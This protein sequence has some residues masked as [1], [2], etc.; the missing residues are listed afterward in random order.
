MGKRLEAGEKGFDKN[1][2]YSVTEAVTLVKKCA[3]AKF[4]ESIELHAA[5]GI[6]V[7]QADQQVRGTLN[8]PHGTGKSKR[9]AVIAK[10][11]KIKEAQAAGA[12]LTGAEDLIDAIS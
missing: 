8:L 5:L 11:E 2:T 10:G 9:V 7:K 4:D 1:K 6:D 12:D 3:T